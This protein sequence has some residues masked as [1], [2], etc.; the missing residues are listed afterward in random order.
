VSEI[1]KS[2]F[3]TDWELM[4]NADWAGLVIVL[5]LTAV[6]VGLYIWVFKPGNKDK[7]E[8]Y[9]D[10][11]NKDDETSGGAGHGQAQ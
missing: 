6:M 5:V 11:V 8:Q 4:T 3:Q 9:R 10:F 1:L 7:F 2:Y